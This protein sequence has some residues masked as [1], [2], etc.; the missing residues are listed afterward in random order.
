MHTISDL[1][2]AERISAFNGIEVFRLRT[3]KF[4]TSSI[5]IFLHDT[6]DVKRAALNAL[7]PAVMRRGCRSL[8]TIQDIAKYL[9]EL[10][11]AS[12]DCGINKKGEQQILQFYVEFVSD[13]FTGQGEGLSLKCFK[14]LY[15]ILTQPVM[16][17]D[18]FRKDYLE[19][20][21]ENLRMLI[22]GRI[23]DKVQYAVERCL[24][25]MCSE[26]PFGVYE[27]GRVED[28]AP[29]TPAMLTD[30]YRS[31]ISELPIR[32]YIA[33]EVEDAALQE[34]VA[35]LSQMK[36]GTQK[37]VCFQCVDKETKQVGEVEEKLNINQSKLS[38]GFRTHTLPQDSDYY[39]LMVYNGILGGGIHSKLFQNVRE[40]QSLA[41]YAFSRLEKFKALMVISCGIETENREKAYRTILQQLEEMKSGN[42]SDYEFEATIKTIETG[43]KS[44]KD[45]QLQMVDFYLSQAVGG[46]ND[47]FDSLIEKTRHVTR[48]DV[49]RLADRIKLDMVYFLSPNAS[50]GEIPGGE[51]GYE[52]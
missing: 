34:M 52:I 14:L 4:K 41:Y 44:L 32:V 25:E 27:Y 43:I 45:S 3:D 17:G 5:N 26:E 12:F 49:I 13:R 30:H 47:D 37:E 50:D 18:A 40:K 6:L 16:E 46:T 11:G 28:L 36:R 21:K 7:L 29:I 33:G 24:E 2:H 35:Q 15:E 9:E 8:P 48:E 20:E 38:L 22:E 1:E 39:T 10:Y 42:I 51:E 23:N 19:Q 31:V